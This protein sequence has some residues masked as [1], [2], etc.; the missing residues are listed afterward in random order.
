VALSTDLVHNAER[1]LS[2]AAAANPFVHSR[3]NWVIPPAIRIRKSGAGPS[4]AAGAWHAASGKNIVFVGQIAPHK[5]V[6]L[7]I[8][9]F[10][11]LASRHA[12][13]HLC[14]AGGVYEENQ[15]WF[16]ASLCASRHQDRIHCLGYQDDIQEILKSAYVLA[17]PTRPSRVH[18]S[19]G[20]VAAEAMVAGVPSVCFRSGALE[21]VVAHGETGLVCDTESAECLAANLEKLISQPDLRDRYARNACLRFEQRYSEPIVRR[22]WLSLLA[23]GLT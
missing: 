5:G 9:A 6:D 19:F 13:I 18:E 10:S 22:D 8:E 20:R 1:S 23:C 21:E 2:M 14:L 17:V 15:A 3:R 7:L 16:D 4:N 11:A 12:E